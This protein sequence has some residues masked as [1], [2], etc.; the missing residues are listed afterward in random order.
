[1]D[2]DWLTLE[3]TR[4]IQPTTD[5]TPEQRLAP[6][7]ETAAGLQIALDEHKANPSPDDVFRERERRVL[8]ASVK[9]AKWMVEQQEALQ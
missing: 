9:H 1:M 2:G 5:K 6:F 7:R 8:E 4:R 3:K